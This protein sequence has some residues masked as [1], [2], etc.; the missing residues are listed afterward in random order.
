MPDNTHVEVKFP[1]TPRAGQEDFVKKVANIVAN[2]GHIAVE[3]PTGMGKTVCVLV[4]TLNIARDTEKKVLYLTRTNSQQ[5]QVVLECR[6]IGARVACVQGRRIMCP[7]MARDREYAHGTPHEL[8]LLCKELRKAGKCPYYERLWA[9][10]DEIIG[11]ILQNMPT[12]E[13]LA[14]KCFEQQVCAYEIM[15]EILPLAEVVTAPYIY[16]FSP[17]IRGNLLDWMGANLEDIIVVVDE[18]HNLPSFAREIL[19]PE[20]SVK[21]MERAIREARDHGDP[22]IAEGIPLTVF[23]SVVRNI[24]AEMASEYIKEDD[25]Y[26]PSFE[27]VH[28]IL[29]HFGG[30]SR[31]VEDMVSNVSIIGEIIREKKLKEHKL[32]RSY[33]ANVGA[34]LSFWVNMGEENIRLIKNRDNP[35]LYAYCLDIEPI[36]SILSHVHASVH[37]SG[38]L[39]PLEEYRDT[40]SLPQ[41][42]VLLSYP[43]P[44]PAE[45]RAIYYVDDVTTRYRDISKDDKILEKIAQYISSIWE[46]FG[47]NTMVFYPSF[48]VM[49]KILEHMGDYVTLGDKSGIYR[50]YKSDTQHEIMEKVVGFKGRRGAIFHAVAGGRIAEGL[51]FPGEELEIVIV[52][53]M[54]YPKPT[55]QQK[56]LEQYYDRKFGKGW[57]YAVHAPTIRKVLQCVGR[58]IRS[59]SDRGVAIILDRRA[60]IMRKYVDIRLSRNILSDIGAF[61]GER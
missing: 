41:S 51:D 49:G 54:P 33:V 50:E 19:T 60:K 32:P 40:L 16:F 43:S 4:A 5:R 58:L 45:N 13:E 56:A 8:S 47:R 29:N 57:E 28:R 31:D 48:S 59:E 15:K 42:T 14:S 38:T 39:S 11:W 27:L 7:I 3:A 1:Y 2:G 61:F 12:A 26:V 22:Y 34:F 17:H 25:G 24:I 18:A 20:L 10:S 53:G 52:A 44:F 30:T 21:S 6:V 46:E 37:I 36:T 9:K 55:A 23:L 35:T